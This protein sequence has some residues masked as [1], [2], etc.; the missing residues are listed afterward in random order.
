LTE[1][2]S[3]IQEVFGDMSIFPRRFAHS[4]EH[5]FEMMFEQVLK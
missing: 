3:P 2:P 5:Y 4:G 1:W